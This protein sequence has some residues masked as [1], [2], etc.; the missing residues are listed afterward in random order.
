[1]QASGGFE[2]V[3]NPGLASKAYCKGKKLHC[4]PGETP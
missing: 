3:D 4:S 1:M 2:S